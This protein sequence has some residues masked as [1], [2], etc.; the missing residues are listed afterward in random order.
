MEKGEMV[1]TYSTHR[2]GRGEVKS[3]NRILI[4]KCELKRSLSKLQRKLERGSKIE[5]G[6]KDI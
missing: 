6:L 4:L 5:T 2:R 1:R 3:T